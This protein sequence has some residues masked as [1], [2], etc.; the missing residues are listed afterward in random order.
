MKKQSNLRQT[1]FLQKI[2]LPVSILFFTLFLT[3]CNSGSKKPIDSSKS[4]PDS[5]SLA[6]TQNASQDSV[7]QFL[8]DAAAKDFHDHQPPA[9]LGFRN[10][11]FKY[12]TKPDAEKTYLI[13]GQFLMKDNQN[14]EDWTH[15]ATI[16]TYPYEQWIGSNALTYCQDSK[17]IT[18]T[19]IDLSGALKSRYDSLQKL[20]K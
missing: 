15:F 12:L 5:F 18:Y 17:E 2:Q 20:S 14:K 10:V 7:V 6:E 9:P 13:C 11:Q 16:K 1:A 19:K 3:S 8:L 4:S